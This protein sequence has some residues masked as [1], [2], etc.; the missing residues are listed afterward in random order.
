MTQ[1]PQLIGRERDWSHLRKMRLVQKPEPV[2]SEP[3]PNLKIH[4]FTA[5]FKEVG[6]QTPRQSIS[7]PHVELAQF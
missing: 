1:Q 6:P 5:L 3:H 7:I 4:I 2:F